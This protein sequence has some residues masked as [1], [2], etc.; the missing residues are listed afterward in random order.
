MPLPPSK[1][2]VDFGIEIDFDRGSPDP[3]RVFRSMS[4]LIDGLQQLD[5]SLVGAIDVSIEPVLMLED[6]ESGSLKT[7]LRSVI[8]STDDKALKSG[9]WKKLV[10][11]YLVKAKYIVLHFLEDKKKISSREDFARLQQ[12]I[13]SAAEETEVR[14]IPLYNPVPLPRLLGSIQSVNESLGQL[15]DQDTAK[16]ISED[17]DARLNLSLEFS[18]SEME[19]LLTS[20]IISS[21]SSMILKV[22]KPD[23]LGESKWEFVFQHGIE[24]KIL[25]TEWLTKF[26]N[27]GVD[28][29]P[30]D[31]LRAQVRT[32][33]RYGYEGDVV[34]ISYSVLKVAEVIRYNPPAQSKL[35]P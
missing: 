14:W 6:I 13:M 15:G 2:T 1:P 22:K 17:G 12:D 10:G 5:R 16:F 20:E 31:A 24:A 35:L 26:Q 19:E 34:G 11:H 3:A 33:I 29:R 7:W 4:G 32:E 9:E 25:D 23:Y 27:R 28:V 30:G 8:T 18:I 21:E